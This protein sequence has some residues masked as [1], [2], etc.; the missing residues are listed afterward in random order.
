M[1]LW[2]ETALLPTGWAER[3]RLTLAD[4]RIARVESGVE[5]QLEP[6]FTSCFAFARRI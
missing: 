4:G 5:P 3:V 2:F 6:R 1:S